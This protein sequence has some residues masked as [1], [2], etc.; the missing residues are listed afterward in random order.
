MRQRPY[1]PRLRQGQTIVIC[2]GCGAPTHAWPYEIRQRTQHFCS[3]ACR[4]KSKASRCTHCDAPIVVRAGRTV[5]PRFCSIQCS[6]AFHRKP[7]ILKNGYRLILR[8]T[9][10]R[11]DHYG[12]VREHILVMESMLNRPLRDREVVHHLNGDKQ[13]NRPENLKLFASNREH[14]QVC[15]HIRSVRNPSASSHTRI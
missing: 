11:A 7:F 10:H 13:D 15:R 1:R 4:R 5:G 2:S 9:H 3:M 12:Y 8:P 6:A 14:L